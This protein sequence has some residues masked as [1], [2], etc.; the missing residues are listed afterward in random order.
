MKSKNTDEM[1][2]VYNKPFVSMPYVA[3]ACIGK[4]SRREGGILFIKGR[5]M[6]HMDLGFSTGILF[7][8]EVKDLELDPSNKA[9]ILT[10][11]INETKIEGVVTTK[12]DIIQAMNNRGYNV[13]YL[14][15]RIEAAMSEI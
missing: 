6:G 11:R 9:G 4:V 13:R 15:E 10:D 8:D 7:D 12:Q 5:E 14:S 1:Y 2:F 3:V